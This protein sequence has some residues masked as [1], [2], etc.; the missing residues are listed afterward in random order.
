[1]SRIGKAKINIP[2]KVTV[3]IENGKATVKGPKGE[4]A[5]DLHPHVT[6]TQQDNILE[7]KVKDENDKQDRSLW[8]TFASLINNMIIGVTDGFTRVL[9]INGVGYTWEAQTKKLVVKAGYSHPV[10]YNLPEG[11][12]IKVDK[13]QLTLTGIDKQ[14]IGAAAA[15]IRSIRKPE[16]YKGKGIKYVEEHILRKAGKQAAGS[17]D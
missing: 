7:I 6:I 14:L 10:E 9:E 15:E 11:I 4:T 3:V 5:I 17:S 13:N 12:E 2:D 1:M 16:P 8:G